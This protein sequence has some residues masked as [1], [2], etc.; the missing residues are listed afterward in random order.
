METEVHA[1]SQ[2]PPSDPSDAA[3]PTDSVTRAESALDRLGSLFSW[4]WI[5]LIAVIV[6]AVVLRFA[7]G[8]GRIEL[9]ELQWHLYAFGFLAGIVACA[10]RDRHVRVDVFRERMTQRA[11]DWID[12][13]GVLLFQLPLIALVLWSALPFVLESFASSEKSASPGGLPYRWILK[14]ALPTFFGLLAFTAIARVRHLSRRLLNEPNPSDA[15]ESEPTA[16]SIE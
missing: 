5:A 10:G 6:L 15:N 1:D 7:F 13:Y 12:L 14:A 8:I 3:V 4:V 2:G 11:R 9:E 16:S